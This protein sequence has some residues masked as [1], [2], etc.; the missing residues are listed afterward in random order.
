M[1]TTGA[2]ARTARFARGTLLRD[3][4]PQLLPLLHPGRN[5]GVDLETLTAGSGSKVWWRCP[6][7]DDH[8]WLAV[9]NN[10]TRPNS[11]CPFCAGSRVSRTN[12]L[13][14]CYPD[15]AAE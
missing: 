12:S 13:A 1:A 2:A 8:E 11:R 15:V 7:G 9:V 6:T 14:G 5:G 4:F 3:A 10:M